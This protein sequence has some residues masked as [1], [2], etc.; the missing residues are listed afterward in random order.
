ME[1]LQKQQEVLRTG[2]EWWDK[3]GSWV[4]RKASAF[5]L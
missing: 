2:K 4:Q 3:N 1:S 5:V